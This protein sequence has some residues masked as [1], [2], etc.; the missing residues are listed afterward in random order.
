MRTGEHLGS[1]PGARPDV[2]WRF[3][4][5]AAIASSPAFS[6]DRVLFG[7]DDGFLFAVDTQ[8]GTAAW[9]AD[10]GTHVRGVPAIQYGSV[11]VADG[12][13]AIINRAPGIFLARYGNA[14][15]AIGD[16]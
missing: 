12:T 6:S 9:V 5:N 13:F 15:L 4:V 3:A 2:L 11:F 1:G 7:S 14:Q 10:L 8:S 16:H